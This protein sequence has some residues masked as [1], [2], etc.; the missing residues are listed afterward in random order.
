DPDPEPDR[1]GRHHGAQHPGPRHLEHQHP[2]P[3]HPEP[4]HPEPQ[5]RGPPPH[6]ARGAA[7]DRAAGAG[8]GVDPHLPRGRGHLPLPAD[9]VLRRQGL[10]RHAAPRGQGLLAGADPVLAAAR[11]HRAQLPRGAAVPGR[12][13]DVLRRRAGGGVGAGLHRRRAP[14]RATRRPAQ[15]AADR[16]AARRHHRGTTRRRL[17]R[18]PPRRGAGPGQGARLLDARRV[19]PVGA[20]QPAARALVAVQRP[21]RARRARPGVPA[22]ELD[23]ARHLGLHRGRGHRPAV[24]LLRPR[25]RGGRA[26]RDVDGPDAGHPRPRR[27]RRRA[28]AGAVPDR[29]GHVL[30][31]RGALA[32]DDRRRR[33]HRGGAEPADRARR[34]PGRRPAQRGRHGGPQARGVLL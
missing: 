22:V 23:R 6:P 33:D 15:P 1:A 19:R 2:G 5:H 27:R 18:R 28:P 32:G 24:D 13:D 17:R 4:Q 7:A 21:A 12:G 11:R 25:A 26:R 14:P 10:G 31:R 3:Q 29:R 30:H 8:V 20:A 34:H 16:A 9:A